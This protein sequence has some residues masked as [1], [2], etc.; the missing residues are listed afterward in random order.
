[1]VKVSQIKEKVE[2]KEGI[3]P[4]QQRL[5]FGGKQMYVLLSYHFTRQF[6]IF[7]LSWRG[8]LVEG[9]CCCLPRQ[10]EIEGQRRNGRKRQRLMDSMIGPTKRQR[11]NITLRV[12]RHCIWFLHCVVAFKRPY[13]WDT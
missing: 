6:I 3:P 12:A 10:T 2:E 9:A 11:A 1:M 7:V 5:I 4:V 13:P 8:C